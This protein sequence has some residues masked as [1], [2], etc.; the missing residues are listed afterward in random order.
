M[1]AHVVSYECQTSSSQPLHKTKVMGTADITESEI[2]PLLGGT[3]YSIYLASYGD[4]GIKGPR[5]EVV[6]VWTLENGE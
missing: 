4:N 5:S 1:F 6:K 3:E 2:G